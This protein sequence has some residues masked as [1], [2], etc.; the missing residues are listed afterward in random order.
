MPQ[1]VFGEHIQNASVTDPGKPSLE[2]K[3]SFQFAN[4][5]RKLRNAW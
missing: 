5:S 4:H 3:D 1:D 2:N